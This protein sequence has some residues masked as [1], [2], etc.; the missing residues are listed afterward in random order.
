M[1]VL[2][3][4]LT[5]LMGRVCDVFYKRVPTFEFGAPARRALQRSPSTMIIDDPRPFAAAQSSGHQQPQLARLRRCDLAPYRL[6]EIV[7]GEA[8]RFDR[9]ARGTDLSMARQGASGGGRVFGQAMKKKS[10]GRFNRGGSN[11]QRQFG[12]SKTVYR[13]P[14]A[15]TDQESRAE[16]RRRKQAAGEVLD[17]VF[18]I[19][20]FAVS[21]Q[22]SSARSDR[23]R[24]RRGWLYN[25]LAT[26]VSRLSEL[27]A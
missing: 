8:S 15:K 9:K 4:F 16:R 25:I 6:I 27:T 18:G 13:N 11:Y 24:R 22:R 1:T 10:S 3:Q 5:R 23:D 14:D 20:R 7:S 12:N 21:T 26:T 17:E 2:H 19:E